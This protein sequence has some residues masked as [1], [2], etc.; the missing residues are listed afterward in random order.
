MLTAR[1]AD[2]LWR[3]CNVTLPHKLAILNHV[4]DPGQIRDNIGAMNTVA[5]TEDGEL[6]GTN[7][8]AGGFFSP[9]AELNLAG[10]DVIVI[11]AGGAARAVLFAL[12]RIKVGQVTILNRNVLKASALVGPFWIERTGSG[13][14]IKPPVGWPARQRQRA[15]HGRSGRTGYRSCP[16]AGRTPW[17]MISYMRRFEL[18]SYVKPK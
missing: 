11:G 14:W 4:S 18:N 1:R 7:T 10:A 13:T 12:S 17:S 6:F 16:A 3:G 15:R 2:E 9:L 5:R 8:D